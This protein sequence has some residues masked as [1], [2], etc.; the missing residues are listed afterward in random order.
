MII[1]NI[2]GI[3]YKKRGPSFNPF[4]WTVFFFCRRK[5]TNFFVK[6]KWTIVNKYF[7]ISKTKVFFYDNMVFI[8]FYKFIFSL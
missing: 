4:E 1:D 3:T 8:L 7:C 5:W 2:I 6:W